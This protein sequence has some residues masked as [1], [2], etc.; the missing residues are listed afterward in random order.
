MHDDRMMIRPLARQ[1][2]GAPAFQAA[3]Q[4]AIEPQGQDVG[5]AVRGAARPHLAK[6]RQQAGAN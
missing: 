3:N 2:I 5:H 6:A 1:H 4:A